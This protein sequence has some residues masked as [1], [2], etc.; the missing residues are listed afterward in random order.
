MAVH[1]WTRVSA[2]TFHS[3]HTSWISEIM[4]VLN[5]GLLPGGFYAQAEQVAREIGPDLLTLQSSAD[6]PGVGSEYSGMTAVAEA[7]PEVSFTETL[8]EVDYYAL[9]RKTLFIRHSSEDQIVAIIEILS[10]GNKNRKHALEQFLDKA[11][12]ALSS[13]YHLLL[14]DLYP[15]G[16]HDPQGIHAALWDQLSCRPFKQPEDRPLTLASYTGGMMPKAFVEPTSVGAELP[17]MPLFLEPGWYVN[18]PL[19]QTY[20]EAYGSVPL[21]WRKVIE[22]SAG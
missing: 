4:K 2:G 5:G 21:R 17:D 10:I 3:F 15:P 16:K 19:E 18:V 14:I 13:E 6:G 12:S 20:I 22:E 7:P 9:K 8:D 11:V 1:D